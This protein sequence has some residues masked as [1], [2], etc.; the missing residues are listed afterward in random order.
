MVTA[1]KAIQETKEFKKIGVN[2]G[3][4]TMDWQR[5]FGGYDYYDSHAYLR[6]ACSYWCFCWCVSVRA[7]A[8][9]PETYGR[10][11]GGVSCL[12]AR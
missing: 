3:P 7:G 6:Y 2:V 8:R 1:A 12:Y 4:A 11:D 10:V 9:R 5:C